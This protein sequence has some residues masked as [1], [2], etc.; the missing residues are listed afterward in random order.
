MLPALLRLRDDLTLRQVRIAV[1]II[2]PGSLVAVASLIT[3][4]LL[5]DLGR[6]SFLPWFALLF[7]GVGPVHGAYEKYG[8]ILSDEEAEPNAIVEDLSAYRARKSHHIHQEALRGDIRK[9]V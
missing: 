3:I 2:I 8:Y 6:P 4:F 5:A 7:L 1:A 9:A